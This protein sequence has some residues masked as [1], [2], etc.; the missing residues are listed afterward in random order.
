MAVK[1][2]KDGESELCEPQYLQYQLDAGYTLIEKPQALE[3]EEAKNDLDTRAQAKKLGIKSHHNKK[4][5]N[6]E[7]EIEGILNDSD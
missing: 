5:S 2:W 1:I 7:K 3:P 4:I 6:L